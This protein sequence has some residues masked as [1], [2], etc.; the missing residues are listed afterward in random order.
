MISLAVM[1]LVAAAVGLFPTGSKANQEPGFTSLKV[2]D[3]EVLIYR[4]EFGVPHIFADTNRGLFEAYG[5]V[6]AQD[7]LWQMELSR[8]A[9]RGRL[10]EI[11]GTATLDSD[12]YARRVGYSDAEFDAQFNRLSDEEKEIFYAYRDGINRYVTEVIM[13][14]PTNK[15]PLE[16]QALGIGVPTPWTARDSVAFGALMTR[17]FGEI[18]GRELTNQNLLNSLIAAHGSEAG[19]AIFNDVRWIND[20]DAPVTI[21][22]ELGCGQNQKPRGYKKVPPPLNTAQLSG[23]SENWPDLQTERDAALRIWERLGVPTKLG[24][25]GWVVS[26]DMSREGKAMLYGGPQMGFNAPEVLHE[27]QLYGGEGFNVTGMAFAGVPA[28]LI[29]RNENIAWTSTTATGDNLDIYMETL[30]NNRNGYMF[31]GEC[32]P[33]EQRVEVINVRGADPVNLTVRRTVHGPV[34]EVRG[35]FAVTEKRAHWMREIDSAR[36]FLEFDRA[37]SLEEFDKA[38]RKIVTSH[39][40]FYA[41]RQ[42]NIAYWQAGQIPVRP[43]GFDTRLPLPG[44]GTA[45]WADE[46][47]PM[48]TAINPERGWLANWNNKPCVDYDN[49]DEQIFG[50]QFRILDVE[51]R[52]AADLVSLEDMRDIPKDIARVSSLGREARFLFDYL[53]DALSAVPPTHPLADRARQV[54]RDWNGSQFANAITSTTLEPGEVIFSAWLSRMRTNLFSNALGDRVGEG[55]LNMLI[56]VLDDAL[57][58]GSGVPPSR[59]Y[60]N[61]QEPYVVMSYT[62]DQ[63][64]TA[65]GSDAAAWSTQPRGTTTFRHSLDPLVPAIGTI[66]RSNRAT[67]AQIV[68]L[69][70]DEVHS[71]DIFTLG[72][73]GFIRVVP[74]SSIVLD[75]H[76]R[77]LLDLYRNFEYKPMHLFLSPKLE[78]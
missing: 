78:E 13:P 5:Y 31:R 30:C 72:Q 38:V 37:S 65:L 69:D 16:F 6:V 48:P 76:F 33:F 77:D 20:P 44:D 17:R 12:R 34:A 29:G 74:P 18:G 60:F 4:D 10:S 52:L 9:A 21:P 35:N 73:S 62:F 3:E 68:V 50:K 63:A 47:L 58:K 45:E 11:L 27:V 2:G 71:E 56:H 41:D 7:R 40:F 22:A 46:R 54:L 75:P 32:R 8:R 66:P 15:L 24:S 57:G 26:P 67:Y 55:S 23:A 39:N 43:A 49:G 61:G 36:P 42:G 19:Y 64:L 28:V 25:Y 59:D 14:D 53:A 70:K 1:A 51:D